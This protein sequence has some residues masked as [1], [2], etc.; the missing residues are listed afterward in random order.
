MSSETTLTDND[1][2]QWIA[3]VPMFETLDSLQAGALASLLRSISFTAGEVIFHHRD[4]GDSMYIVR[5][6]QVR[7]WVVDEDLKEVTLAEL[8]PGAFFG[9]LSLLDGSSRSANAAAAEYSELLRLSKSDFREFMLKNPVVALS[10]MSELGTRLRQ[11][12]QL[13][14]Q[15]ATRNLNEE[16]EERMSL[17]D[18]IADRIASFGGSWPFIFL[19]SG[20]LLSWICLNLFLVWKNTGGPFNENGSFDPYPFIA[21]NLMLSMTAAFQAPIIMMSQ[22]RAGKKDRLAAEID[23]K[24]NLKSEMMIE[25]LT[26]RMDRLQNEQI[27]ELLEIARLTKVVEAHLGEPHHE[28]FGRK[29]SSVS[30]GK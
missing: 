24:V 18:R 20:V 4:P 29:S 15:R 17:G 12:T 8:G 7:I 28:E 11:T 19:F 3:A 1:R 14:S 27:E 10:M 9:E 5:S 2:T 25:E 22:N 13:V 16:I 26:R 30:P 21:L 6:G 23:F